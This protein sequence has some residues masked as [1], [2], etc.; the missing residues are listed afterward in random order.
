MDTNQI[1]RLHVNELTKQD[2]VDK[3]DVPCKPVMLKGITDNWTANSNWTKES[4]KE[5]YGSVEF[6]I[7]HRENQRVCLKLDDYMRYSDL[8]HDEIPLYVFDAV[9]GEHAPDM[10]KD[11]S[12]HHFFDEDYLEL[13]GD[14]RPNY[15]WFVMGPARSGSPWH[16][17]PHGTSAWNS[18]LSG[19]V[20]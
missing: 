6:R 13:L 8:Q 11:Y 15:R 17:D 19:Q 3:Y 20:P 18:L 16:I 1:D 12:V 4:L 10:L 2:F 14:I 5:K 9:F 7:S